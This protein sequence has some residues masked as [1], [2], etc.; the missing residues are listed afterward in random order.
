V[1]ERKLRSSELRS[2]EFLVTPHIGTVRETPNLE[3]RTPNSELITSTLTLD[4]LA[5]RAQAA[6]LA[7]AIEEELRNRQTLTQAL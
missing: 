4:Q 3:L 7:R 6:R 5:L 1:R 2:S